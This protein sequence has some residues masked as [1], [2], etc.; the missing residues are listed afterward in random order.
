MSLSVDFFLHQ[1]P[2]IVAVDFDTIYMMSFLLLFK[3]NILEP[4]SGK[5]NSKKLQPLGSRDQY[6]IP[7]T[8]TAANMILK[9]NDFDEMTTNQ[10]LQKNLK[11]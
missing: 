4:S 8:V 9:N 5:Q 10:M 6:R 7:G 2:V 1:W 3:M 11:I